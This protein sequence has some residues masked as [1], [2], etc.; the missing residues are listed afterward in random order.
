[1][2]QL[3]VAYLDVDGDI[4]GL[5]VAFVGVTKAARRTD[6]AYYN[7]TYLRRESEIFWAVRHAH[8]GTG[9]T[10]TKFVEVWRQR[11]NT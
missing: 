2:Y 9:I 3:D 10:F 1:M 4:S 8:G 11:C 7:L 5:F 6:R